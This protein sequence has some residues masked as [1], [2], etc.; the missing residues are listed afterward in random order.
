MTRLRW[1]R[2]HDEIPVVELGRTN[3]I[4]FAVVFLIVLGIALYFGFTK[5]VP[6]KHGFRLNA[7]FNSALN[8]KGKSPV[9]IAGVDVGKVSHIRREG[10][11]GVVSME[12]DSRG[13]PIHSDATVKIRPRIFLEG[14]WFV[15]LQPGSP[16]APK[17]SSGATLPVTQT[18]DPVQLDQVLDALN[19][20]TRQNLQN[21]L[22]GYGDGLT[23]KPNAEEDAEQD[24]IVRGISGAQAVNR[25]YQH[26]TR[27][28]RGASVINQATT[29][30]DAHDLSKLIAGIGRVTAALNVHEQ[31][32]GELISNFNTFFSSFAAQASPLQRT[33]SLLPS[34]LASIQRGFAS[35]DASF[36]PTR[37]F[38]HDILPGVRATNATVAATIPW[39][40][41]VRASLAPSELGGVAK[42]LV[43]AT[44]SLA[45][46]T[47]EQT[48]FYRQ[49]DLFNKCIT[50]VLLPAGNTKIQDG[51][52]T[53]GVENYKEF[54]YGLVGL[55]GIDQNFDGNGTFTHFLLGSG[56]PTI[57]SGQAS[58]QGTSIKGLRLLAHAT[59]APLGTRPAFPA[60]EPAYK[61]LVPCYTQTLPEFNG[62]ASQGPA[63]GTG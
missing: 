12:I 49:T 59:L 42:G 16:S 34:S 28:L 15:E 58:V 61:P 18:A 25:A 20:D 5:H 31:E 54:W 56:G 45:Q 3:P 24:P 39:I 11:T 29:G 63:D 6:F 30:T 38:A 27:P 13:L 44:P 51:T 41:Q 47:A 1:W 7:V 22:I 4:R 23:R 60:S 17:L 55:A 46:L 10:S 50:K 19:T 62:P 48:P 2:R 35:L 36:P 52:S 21:F 8:I 57:R 26:G 9:R 37:E 32:L 40:E 53:S 33:V 43:Q 14:N